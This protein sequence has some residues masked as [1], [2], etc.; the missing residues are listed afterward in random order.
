MISWF[1][2]AQLE[3]WLSDITSSC[4]LGCLMLKSTCPGNI[5]IPEPR[6]SWALQLVFSVAFIFRPLSFRPSFWAKSRS[7]L[8]GKKRARRKSSNFP[9]FPES[10]CWNPQIQRHSRIHCVVLASDEATSVTCR[11]DVSTSTSYRVCQG[12]NSRLWKPV[13]CKL[14]NWPLEQAYIVTWLAVMIKEAMT[15]ATKLGSTK[16]PALELVR[17][18]MVRP[19][20][21]VSP[22][23]ISF[24]S[25]SA[26]SELPGFSWTS[27]LESKS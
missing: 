9:V 8:L 24:T 4:L 23:L 11:K 7:I 15:N 17:W 13:S 12:W 6:P 20:Q 18:K 14:F 22:M 2:V 5:L 27:V 25:T 16:K 19:C 1:Y 3:L 21:K 10:F 26:M